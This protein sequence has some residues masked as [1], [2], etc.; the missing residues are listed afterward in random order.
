MGEVFKQLKKS[1]DSMGISVNKKVAS[2][3]RAMNKKDGEK[4]EDGTGDTQQ[5][6]I[7]EEDKAI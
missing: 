5:D 4:N 2:A 7:M 1:D 6:T 3:V